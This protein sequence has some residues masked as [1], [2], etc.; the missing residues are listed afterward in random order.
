[1]RR[2]LKINLTLHAYGFHDTA[3]RAVPGDPARLYDLEHFVRLA[4]TA[5]RGL[6]DSVFIADSLF[7]DPRG[8]AHC[9]SSGLYEP[10]TLLS[11]LAARTRHIGL[12]GTLSTGFSEPFNAARIIASL[13]R[14]SGGRAGWNIV[15]SYAGASA[16]NFG[17]D[18]IP[19]H[20]E[21]YRRAEEFVDV[22]LA[23]WAS[24]APDAFRPDKC[25]GRFADPSGIRPINHVGEHFSVQGPLNVPP[26]PQGRPFLV[27]AGSSDTGKD[28]G[29][30]YAEAIYTAQRDLG[31]AQ[32]FYRDIK[33]RARRAG[34]DPDGVA[35]LPGIC[36]ILGSTEREAL[37][38]YQ[39]LQEMANPEAGLRQLSSKF[40]FDLSAFPLDE[41]L[42]DLRKMAAGNNF[43]RSRLDLILD[44][45]GDGELTLR[46]VLAE[47]TAGRG[48]GVF[49][50]TPEQLADHIEGWFTDGA[51][52]GF[53]LMPQVIDSGLDD[54]V[55]HVVPIL[56][57]RGLFRRE[58]G[59][60]TLRSHYQEA[61]DRVPA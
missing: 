33:D 44:I 12:I 29:A 25:T 40:G 15:T 19:P 17:L 24:W 51:S 28:F 2:Q 37:D 56:Q 42:P 20:A 5:E 41:P 9:A 46:Q 14:L 21:R 4:A 38:S 16:R 30:R 10:F 49:V 13:D 54:F 1:M 61:F 47:V 60:V 6:L 27:Q 34:R 3:W 22:V 18:D 11:A 58:Y 59:G 23:L 50:G 52:D 57:R 53:N 48:H 35:V 7:A 32:E 43:Q 36:T 45:A 55:D 31:P 39:Q 26:S 8:L